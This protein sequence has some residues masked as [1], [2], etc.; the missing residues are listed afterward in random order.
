METMRFYMLQNKG[1]QVD[2][3]RICG[4]FAKVNNFIEVLDMHIPNDVSLWNP[5]K[6]MKWQ[7][8]AETEALLE[9][10]GPAFA[11]AAGLALRT[12]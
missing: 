12:L 6:E 2:T 11:V 9:Q 4:E 8:P 7:V 3:L 5:V 10:S 1:Q